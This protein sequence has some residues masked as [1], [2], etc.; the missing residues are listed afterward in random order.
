MSILT[1][2]KNKIFF[3]RKEEEIEM[4]YERAEIVYNEN[5]ILNVT[6]DDLNKKIVLIRGDEIVEGKSK[7]YS[8][9]AI[10]ILQNDHIPVWDSTKEQKFIEGEEVNLTEV[11]YEK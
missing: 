1:T 5:A 11:K 2:I 8:K 9:S 4:P 10:K 7:P 6:F 3:W